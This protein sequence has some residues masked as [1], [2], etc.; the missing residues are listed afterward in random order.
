MGKQWLSIHKGESSKGNKQN[1]QL[2]ADHNAE[3]WKPGVQIANFG[4]QL[5]TSNQVEHTS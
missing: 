5:V 4:E 3:Q 1:I 2:I